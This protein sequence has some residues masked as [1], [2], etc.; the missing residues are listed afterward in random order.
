MPAA[1]KKLNRGAKSS[2]A[3]PARI[4]VRTYSMP[5]ARVYASSS[6]GV[7]PASCMWYPLMEM[8]LNRGM[9]RDVQPKMSAMI[10]IEGSGG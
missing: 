6:S 9:W 10:R 2:I 8:E 1:Q 3:R 5:S 7:A 4:P